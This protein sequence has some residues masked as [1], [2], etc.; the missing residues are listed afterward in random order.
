VVVQRIKACLNG[1]RTPADHPAVPISPAQLAAAARAAVTVGAEAIHVHPRDAGG[2][3]S[4]HRAEIGAAVAA[5]R[6]ACPGVPV[7][8]T[9]GLWVAGGDP[10]TRQ[11]QIAAW[12]C[13]DPQLRPDFASVNLSEDSWQVL[14]ATLPGA[15][16][17]VEAGVWSVEDAERAGDAPPGGW[18]RILV[19]IPSVGP[20]E[21]VD[22]ARKILARLTQTAPGIPVLLHGEGASCWEL[23]AEAGRR[24]L[25]TRIG[26]EDVTTGPAGE[27]VDDN[28]DLVRQ[29]L[30]ILAV[31]LG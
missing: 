4:L 1:S 28:A 6:A 23:V 12:A 26:L 17:G 10:R 2:R 30:R 16:I 8:V 3:E 24:G 5:V 15:G 29:A 19:E 25:P 27:E 18:L 22:R 7:G 20:A 9:T 31:T 13:L 11:E 14:A 21:A